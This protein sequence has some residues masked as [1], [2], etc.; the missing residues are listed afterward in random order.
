LNEG[1]LHSTSESDG[2][3]TFD[4][5]VGIDF[6][7]TGATVFRSMDPVIDIADPLATSA[8]SAMWGVSIKRSHP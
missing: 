3:C 8:P 6:H 7:L 5:V 1:P 4:A 2:A